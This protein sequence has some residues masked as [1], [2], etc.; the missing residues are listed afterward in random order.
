MAHRSRHLHMIP[1]YYAFNSNNFF[2]TEK[3]MHIKIF[4]LYTNNT[5]QHYLKYVIN[6]SL[7]SIIKFWEPYYSETTGL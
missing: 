6:D 2:L 3:N 4:H 1:C 5:D 7:I